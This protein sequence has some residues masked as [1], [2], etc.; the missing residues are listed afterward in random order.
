MV[1]WKTPYSR[2]AII[3]FRG[4]ERTWEDSVSILPI[5]VF[6]NVPVIEI[7]MISNCILIYWQ[8]RPV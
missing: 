5:A 6:V 4:C 2:W 8:V 7:L 1:W 3:F